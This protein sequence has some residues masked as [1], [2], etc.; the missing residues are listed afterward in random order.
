MK[1]SIETENAV[2]FSIELT[3]KFC[4]LSKRADERADLE[5]KTFSIG[6][7]YFDVKFTV[8]SPF[9]EAPYLEVTFENCYDEED[10]EFPTLQLNAINSTH[11]LKL[12]REVEALIPEDWY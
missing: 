5:P 12:Y 4:E 10:R 2:T 3:R 8:I 11:V 9:L 7:D 6:W 1:T